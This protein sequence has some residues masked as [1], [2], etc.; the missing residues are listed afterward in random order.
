MTSLP[1]IFEPPR[2]GVPPRHLADLGEAERRVAVAELGLPAYR[3]DQLSRHY[4]ARLQTDPE[5]MTDLP[6]VAR[7]RLGDAL[8]PALL[9]E[10][11]HLQTDAGTTRK[12]LWRLHDGTLVESVLMRYPATA[13]RPERI[14]V[15]VSSQ[16]G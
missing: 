16:A 3:A 9:T 4:F 13:K 11:R 8:L 7:A 12:S 5:A 10:V 2:R 1:L 14:T 6:P 15:C